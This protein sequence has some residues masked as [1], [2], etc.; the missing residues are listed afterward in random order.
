MSDIEKILLKN[1]DPDL[2]QSYYIKY[3]IDFIIMLIIIFLFTI[4]I[5]YFYILNYIPNIMTN[6][7]YNKC[8]PKYMPYVHFINP[9]NNKTS[10]EQSSDNFNECVNNSLSYNTR[11]SIK[12]VYYSLDILTKSYDEIVDSMTD[13]KGNFNN[14]RTNISEI[15]ARV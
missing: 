4:A 15:F 3:G 12:P 1:F 10:L 2:K 13:I 8:D 11:D 14:I 9:D 7:S 6:W 5:I